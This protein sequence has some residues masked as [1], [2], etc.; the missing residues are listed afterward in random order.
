[1]TTDRHLEALLSVPTLHGPEVSPNGRW[2]A[3]SWSRLGPAADVFAAPTDG[4]RTPIR[5]TETPDDTLVVSWT[6]D[7]EAVVVGQDRDG[8]ERAR[9]FLV[10]LS[11]P[12]SLEPLTE[13]SPNYYV[14]GGQVHGDGRWLVYGANLD[15]ESG[16]E[17]EETWIY[18]HDLETGERKVLARP[19]RGNYHAPRLEGDL[20][21]YH[22]NDLDP[23]GL[24][25][26]L[27]DIEGR[28]D[29]EILNFGPKTKAY[30]SWFPDGRRVLFVV[31]AESHRR[32]GIWEDGSVRWLMDDPRRNIE[33]AFVPPC[34]GPVV[35]AEMERARARA[36]LLDAESGVESRLPEVPG[37]LIP[38]SPAGGGRWVGLHYSARQPMDLISF[39]PA[40]NIETLPSLT[41]LWERATLDPE[42]LAPAED[43]M[44]ESVDGLEVQGWLYR[45]RGAG[46]IV[47]VHGGP[48]SHAEDRFNAQI[49]YLVSRGFDVLTPNYRGSTGFGLEFQEAIKEDGWGSREQEDIRCG[50]EALIRAGIARPG[51]VGVT[52]T[53]YGGYSAWWAITHFEPYLVAAA[54]PVCG[55]TDLVVDYHATRPDLRP[56]SEEMMD[57]SPEEVPERYRERSPINF[58]KNIRG[59]LLIVQGLQD[60]NVTPD[61]VHAVTKVLDK[62]E[63]PYE[64]LTFEDEGHGI[65][66]K[67][68]LKIHY[69]RLADFFEAAFS[70]AH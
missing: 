39:D 30:G 61:N 27:V 41:G 15:A 25:V 66:R 29:R 3:W 2:V 20:V 17:I 16:E 13:A 12:G 9:L 54:A 11:N 5:L 7:S 4:S 36:R 50:I 40:E 53:S 35:V 70:E 14:R 58:V 65:A 68:N 62:L 43:F 49:Q 44:W 22:R 19:M 56:Y 55:M 34:G 45:G 38:L 10:R 8:D 28:N 64:L 52:G 21:L 46:T 6:P 67:E 31:E 57:G 1:V 37:S 42:S 18:R 32:L 23:A 59:K 48:T 24:Q 63:I 26:W 33:Y 51:R 69:R 47:L 60:P